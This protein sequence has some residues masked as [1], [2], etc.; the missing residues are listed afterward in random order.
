[1]AVNEPTAD[2]LAELY[3]APPISWSDVEA[4][5][6]SPMGQAPGTG[7]PDHHTYW[8]ATSD[9]DGRPHVTGVG[10]NRMDGRWY[11]TAGPGTRKARN[12][13]RDGRASLGISAPGFDCSIQGSVRRVTDPDLLER[14]AAALRE[15]GWPCA[16]DGDA[17]TAE[18][19]A[20]SAGPPPWYLWEL[21]PEDVF[22]VAT[23]TDA[24]GGAT[25]F[26]F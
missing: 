12:L 14:S 1:M 5:L 4:A 6:D 21:T 19:S 23:T 13:E 18:F 20:P 7:G 16:V 8:L 3:D 26:R 22:A 25:A 9:A 17:I 24:T 10:V 2:N 15:E 11:F